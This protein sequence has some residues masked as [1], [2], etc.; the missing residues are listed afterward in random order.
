[1]TVWL[2][3]RD[4]A[5]NIVA[6]E[7]ASRYG[8]AV[9]LRVGYFAGPPG[10]YWLRAQ[11]RLHHG[12][13]APLTNAPAAPL[14]QVTVIPRDQELGMTRLGATKD[15]HADLLTCVLCGAFACT[16]TTMQNGGPGVPAWHRTAVSAAGCRPCR[17]LGR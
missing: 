4:S 8:S 2:I 6:S 16:A 7:L 5:Q 3:A 1:V 15:E 10:Q 11:M 17:R 12:R 14:V 9:E 13:G